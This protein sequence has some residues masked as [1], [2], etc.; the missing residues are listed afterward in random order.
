M[1]NYQW[2]KLCDDSK[3]AVIEGETSPLLFTEA[4]GAYRCH[5]SL[6]HAEGCSNDYQFS[7]KPCYTL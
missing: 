5:V 4:N 7:S 1:A 2:F 6:E 3:F